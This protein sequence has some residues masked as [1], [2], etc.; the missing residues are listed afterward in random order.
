MI[1]GTLTLILAI[2]I[3][4][5][6]GTKE[7]AL[8][9]TFQLRLAHHLPPMHQ[10]HKGVFVPWAKELEKRTGGRVKV[11]IF[12]SEQ[13]GSQFEMYD[14]LLSGTADITLINPS[15]GKGRFPLDEIFHLPFFIPGDTGDPVGAPIRTVLYEKYISPIHFKDVKLL[16][17][18]RFGMNVIQTTKKPIRTMEDIKGMVIGV[19]GGRNLTKL[20][21]AVGASPESSPVPEMYT[22]LERGVIDGQAIPIEAMLAFKLNEVVKYVT[23]VNAEGSSF[24]IAMNDKTWNS[25]PPDIQKII[26]DMRPWVE[27][28]QAKAWA[29]ATGYAEMVAKKSGIEL[30]PLSPEERARWV[31]IAKPID[32][33]WVKEMDAKGFPA[34]EMYQLAEQM[35]SK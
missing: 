12:P 10:Q 22:N 13:L 35:M 18:G 23:Q 5:I 31:E 16:W 7:V 25:L 15:V 30:I 9:K 3:I 2:G 26:E 32:A 17:T 19:P 11:K 28:I 33:E 29:G 14:V 20:I 34:S 21:Q 4:V 24:L 8:A 1:L 27:G 6:G